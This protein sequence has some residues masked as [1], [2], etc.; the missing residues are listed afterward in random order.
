MG[1]SRETT[2]TTNTEPWAK[3]QPY[4]GQIFKEGQ[5]LFNEGAGTA[6]APF[7][8]VVPF[9]QPT[10]QAMTGIQNLASQGNP[11]SAS[12]TTA[13]NSLISGG[14][15]SPEARQALQSGFGV[16]TG[17][18]RMAP[19]GE[20]D[21]RALMGEA[22][23]YLAPYARGDYV[24]GGSPQFRAAL[25][26]QS[27]QLADDINRGFSMAGRYGSESHANTVGEQV[28]NFRNQ[29]LSSEIAREQGLQQQSAAQ[30]LASRAG[31][32]G[33]IYNLQGT[34]ISN[35]VNA[36]Q[37]YA[38]AMNQGAGT[39][40]G[41]IDR[42]GDIYSQMFAPFQQLGNVGAQYEDLATR[43]AQDSLS[44]FNQEQMAPWDLLARYNAI[45]GQA[46]ELGQSTA[47]T[48]P[49]PS[50]LQ[51]GIGGAMQGAS[52]GGI[53]GAVLGGLGGLIF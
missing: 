45:I 2:S 38:S 13:A 20:A 34:D 19:G 51:T 36:G 42:T 26:H 12:A 22:S 14:G 52:I 9:S 7:S 17:Q 16:A 28:G 21:Y 5:R 47:S 30:L 44:R 32:L 8:T 29:A 6:S 25:D 35:M 4:Y 50:R 41:A 43:Q 27:G 46:G 39:A 53:P 40:L 23:S 37:G 31:A 10:M 49:G 3:S 24:T 15:I 48:V 1:G 33:N 18:N 11:F